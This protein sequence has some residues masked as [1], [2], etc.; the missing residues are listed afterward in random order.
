[1]KDLKAGL[2]CRETAPC[3]SG[4]KLINQVTAQ[5]GSGYSAPGMM[6][7]NTA[8]EFCD[9]GNAPN[10]IISRFPS[11]K[12]WENSKTHFLRLFGELNETVLVDTEHSA[13]HIFDVQ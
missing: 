9:L 7:N 4:W 11:L 6:A 2:S 13:W 10:F 3:G 12:N 8:M 5:S 1:M